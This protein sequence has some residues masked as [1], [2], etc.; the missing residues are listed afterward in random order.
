M[1]GLRDLNL[2]SGARNAV[3]VWQSRPRRDSVAGENDLPK[4][5]RRTCA[6][7]NESFS[8]YFPRERGTAA[9]TGALGGN[10]SPSHQMTG[11][12]SG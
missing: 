10:D 5:L 12:V 9:L 11:A 1:S 2:A 8:A 3:G 6:S 4:S 7:D